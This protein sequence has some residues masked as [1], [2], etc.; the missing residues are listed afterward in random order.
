MLLLRVPQHS[1]RQHWQRIQEQ[2]GI[3]HTIQMMTSDMRRLKYPGMLTLAQ[4]VQLHPEEVAGL[5][6]AAVEH[7]VV[8]R[9][10]MTLV[11][12]WMQPCAACKHLPAR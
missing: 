12:T 4:Q 9:M 1:W 10:M 2:K 7:A 6:V 5:T 3:M 11:K 8:K